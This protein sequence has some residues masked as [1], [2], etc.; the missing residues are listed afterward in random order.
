[1]ESNSLEVEKGLTWLVFDSFYIMSAVRNMF[2]N[3]G[4]LFIGSVKCDRFNI[5][6]HKIHKDGGS[7]KFGEW[8]SIYNEETN[9]VYTYH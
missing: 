6:T 3:E 4:Q 8:K 7:D 1:M 5:E 2:I 9:E